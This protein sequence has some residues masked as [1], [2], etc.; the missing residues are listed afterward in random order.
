M[1]AKAFQ[2]QTIQAALRRLRDP[3][4]SRRFLVADEAGLGK[5]VVA[6]DVIR[7]LAKRRGHLDVF[8]LC[9]SLS[10]ARQNKDN[11]L[12]GIEDPKQR[13]LADVHLDRLTLLPEG[14]SQR[15]G[16][17][18]LYS[19]SPQT[20]LATGQTGRAT[21]RAFL[22][23]LLGRIFDRRRLRGRI[24]EALRGSVKHW[25]KRV[26]QG[27]RRAE[28]LSTSFLREFRCELA[29]QFGLSKGARRPT[30]VERIRDD[31]ERR[32]RRSVVGRMRAALALI[33]LR[34]VRPGLVILDEFQRF[35]D[36]LGNEEDDADAHSIMSEV[37]RGEAGGEAPAVLLLSATPYRLLPGWDEGG[38]EAAYERFF[39]LQRFLHGGDR[40]SVEA[41][42]RGLL[43]YAAGLRTYPKD[44]E[45]TLAIRRRVQRR[46]KRVMVRTERSQGDA[47]AE[48]RPQALV[49]VDLAPED[50]QSFRR[51]HEAASE[52]H[53]P[54]VVPCW[55]SIP[56]PL[57]AMDE[58]YVV[59]QAAALPRLSREEEQAY[60][61]P[62]RVQRYR[63][64]QKSN[65]R[66]RG[67][68]E[69]VPPELLRLPWLPPALPWW[70]LGGCFARAQ[71]ACGGEP[72]K[73]LVFSRFRAVPRALGAVVS[74]EAERS[75]LGAPYDYYARGGDRPANGLKAPPR[76]SFVISPSE[77]PNVRLRTF[78]MF[79]PLPTL[80]FMGD[81]LTLRTESGRF[82]SKRQ[83]LAGVRRRLEAWFGV[84]PGRRR[85]PLWHWAKAL[86]QRSEW[87]D[88]WVKDAFGEWTWERYTTARG[89]YLAAQDFQGKPIDWEARP[90]RSE[91]QLLA[92]F[93][94][95][96]PGNVLWRAYTRVFGSQEQD[97]A[98]QEVARVS[99]EGLARY[100]DQPE[101]HLVLAPKRGGRRPP[102][103]ASVRRAVWEGNLESVLD[104]Y[105]ATTQGL[106][107]E[108]QDPRRGKRVLE[109]LHAALTTRAASARLD[110]LQGGRRKALRTG[111]MRCH[112][113]MQLRPDEGGDFADG[114][115]ARI[116]SDS[117]RKAFNS[118]FRPFVLATTSV[119]QE[120]LD[121]HVYCNHLVHW[122]L[123]SNPV[124]LEQREGR[125][126]RYG[127]LSVRRALVE[128]LDQPPF[129]H[130]SPWRAL[131][132]SWSD[133]EDH[134]G[135]YP[136]WSA[137]EERIQ[138]TVFVAPFSQEVLR[139]R[140]LQRAVALYRLTLG[141][142][143]PA[144]MV[145]AL[146]Q[147]E[148][149]LT[150]DARD[151]RQRWLR[152]ARL[153]LTP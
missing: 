78:L 107:V 25:D 75:A 114:K 14:S 82:P 125:I 120:G 142:P 54:W 30:I 130:G 15:T 34:T 92:E 151:E 127:G 95:L 44:Q 124:D 90:T 72:S 50:V 3:N 12:D 98:L 46:L 88:E 63:P 135:R 94:L 67:L 149:C 150:P 8:Y 118:P 93:A 103:A 109:A 136:W 36:Y 68:L 51:F 20:S 55:A 147:E 81:P 89:Q 131:A 129:T 29:K 71:E 108:E 87:W 104:E 56:Y 132:E 28:G 113:G 48:L 110:P 22:L 38:A 139:L 57:Q 99:F 52:D 123:P 62:K 43:D 117:V 141:Q 105:F 111:K 126:Q 69:S 91:L 85:R 143:N 134:G 2:E 31:L 77:D 80:A 152:E 13:E 49:K 23:A 140:R 60:L 115:G 148:E 79:M 11:L 59:K 47:A 39:T 61:L 64:V 112:A 76:G 97:A 119:G 145:E 86:E 102:H 9:S 74:Y 84:Q 27:R 35:F 101:F 53:E 65:P 19:L 133:L 7:G 17:F 83:A 153:D 6:R 100:L 96:A 128:D 10:I 21:E 73:L 1:K 146:L 106:G 116:R 122:D 144:H 18:T 40:A 121:F 66:L 33:A 70:R 41:I 45:A 26:T 32:G 42:R 137:G 58:G 37:L 5:T 138:R 16:P 24:E 4:G